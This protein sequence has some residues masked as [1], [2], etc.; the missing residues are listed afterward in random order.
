MY[1]SISPRTR[2]YLLFF[3]LFLKVAIAVGVKW[4]LIVAVIYISLMS[5]DDDGIFSRACWFLYVFF[6]EIPLSI[7]NCGMIIVWRG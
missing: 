3:I 1:P 6:G 2:Q 7:L 4:Y 5:K